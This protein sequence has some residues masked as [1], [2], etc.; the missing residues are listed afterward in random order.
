[1]MYWARLGVG[2]I[3]KMTKLQLYCARRGNDRVPV[4]VEHRGKSLGLNVGSPESQPWSHHHR[5]TM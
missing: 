5:F 4:T 1:M 2:G 3:Y